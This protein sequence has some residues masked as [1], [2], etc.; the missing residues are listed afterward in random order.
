MQK[1]DVA[2]KV[3]PELFQSPAKVQTKEQPKEVLEESRPQY[4]GNPRSAEQD[5]MH[6]ISWQ[7]VDQHAV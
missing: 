4:C 6:K 2:I 1:E 3:G 5:A 7:R